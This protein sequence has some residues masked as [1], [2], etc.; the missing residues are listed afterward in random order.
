MLTNQQSEKTFTGE[1]MPLIFGDF[2]GSRFDNLQRSLP[3]GLFTTPRSVFHG[4]LA[5]TQMSFMQAEEEDL[6]YYWETVQVGKQNRV[7]MAYFDMFEM[8]RSQTVFL[9]AVLGGGLLGAVYGLITLLVAFVKFLLRRRK[10]AAL[11]VPGNRLYRKGNSIAAALL[12][13]FPLNLILLTAQLMTFQPYGNYFWQFV[14]TT[15]I[16]ISMIAALVL[17]IRG[18]LDKTEPRKKRIQYSFTGFFTAIAL[19]TIAYWQMYQFWVL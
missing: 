17:L 18:T 4:P 3:D 19:F 15:V 8:T 1:I 16:G 14:L 10:Q 9:F 6:N 11:A 7:Q 12:L 5:Y 2:N 13:L